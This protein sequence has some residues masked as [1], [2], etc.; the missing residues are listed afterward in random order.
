MHR[1]VA[2]GLRRAELDVVTSAEAGLLGAPDTFPLSHAHA[3]GRVLVTQDR[4]FTRL[5]GEG[6]PHSGIAYSERG[7]RSIRQIIEALILLNDVY[8]P[9]EMHGR[10]EYI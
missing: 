5:N 6:W 3:A 9:E 2:N 4:D 8:D 1:G 10:L 7:S